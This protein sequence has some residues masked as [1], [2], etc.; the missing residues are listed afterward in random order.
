MSLILNTVADQAI[1]DAF[2]RE[3]N[4]ERRLRCLGV[5]GSAGVATALDPMMS[6]ALAYAA[7]KANPDH[8]RYRVTMRPWPAHP[9]AAHVHA[10]RRLQRE[11]MYVRVAAE[12]FDLE[13]DF[14]CR[15]AA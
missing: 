1:A 14:A 5:R 12:T 15:C 9:H 7:F 13:A 6:G 2:E 11:A 8:P 4:V 3:R 10:Y